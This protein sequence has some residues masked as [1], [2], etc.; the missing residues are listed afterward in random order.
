MR[1]SSVFLQELRVF[2]W[3]NLHLLALEEPVDLITP[4]ETFVFKV[5][6]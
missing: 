2:R 6:C 3:S 4:N 1:N 5:E